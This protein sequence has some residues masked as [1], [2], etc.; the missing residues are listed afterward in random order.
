MKQQ[1]FEIVRRADRRYSWLLVEVE[2][3]RRRVLARSQR[4]HRSRKRVEKAIAELRTAEILP[5]GS[6]DTSPWEPTTFHVVRG[7]KPLIVGSSPVVY[8]DSPAPVA[9][10]VPA[11]VEMPAAAVAAPV[12]KPA[13]K[14]VAKPV[15]R[16]GARAS[17]PKPAAKPPA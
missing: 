4:D 5:V 16:R 14:A 15:A 2:G 17:R 11:V 10:D 6:D 13:A 3:E 1:R 7:V 12:P 9:A 8:E